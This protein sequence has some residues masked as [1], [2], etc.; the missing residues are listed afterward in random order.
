MA[1]KISELD[2]ID[3]LV[4]TELIEFVQD[5]ENRKGTPDDLKTFIGLGTV[6]DLD[7][8][9]DGTLAANSDSVVPSQKAVK[10][11]ADQLIA[12]A[13]AMVFKGVIDCSTNPDYPAANRGETYRVSVAG[14]IGGASGPNVEVGDLLLCLTDSTASGNH[15]TVGA[16]WAIT[17]TNLDGAV[18]GPASSVNNEIALF[19]GVSGKVIKG[20][21]KTLADLQTASFTITH[22]SAAPLPAAELLLRLD[23]TTFVMTFAVNLAG[24]K[25]GV[26]VAD[27]A[28]ANADFPV[29]RNG[30]DV[31]TVRFAAAATAATFIAASG[32]VLDPD[33]NDYLEI[34]TPTTP[35]ATLARPSFTIA[36]TR[37]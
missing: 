22:P 4:G 33:T 9:T 26:K 8:D 32:F 24:S 18:I 13:D 12:A 25:G 16:Q 31:G 1:G 34:Y 28:T 29:K 17:Q 27:V 3:P 10:T 5:S 30:V 15:A 14:K 21:G 11:Y 37:G 2:P 36:L 23:A 6:A 35:D 19:D 20:S 7:V